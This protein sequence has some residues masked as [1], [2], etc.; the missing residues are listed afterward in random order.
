VLTIAVNRCRTWAGRWSKR[1][2]SV[3]YLPDTA[4]AKPEDDSVELRRELNA[5]MEGLRPEYRDA[6]VLFHEQGCP[7]EEIAERLGRPVG[8]I[9]T[10]LHRA[11]LE[12][13]DLLKGR[14]MVETD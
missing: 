6:F 10:W 2:Q 4:A 14:G 5:A 7:Y 13:L 3:D 12:L 9:K 11:R 8:T 1:P